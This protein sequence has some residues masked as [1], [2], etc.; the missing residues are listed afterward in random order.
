MIPS[1]FVRCDGLSV[2][3][4]HFALVAGLGV[5]LFCGIAEADGEHQMMVF[6]ESEFVEIFL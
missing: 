3:E 1:F 4:F 6:G 5:G 2:D